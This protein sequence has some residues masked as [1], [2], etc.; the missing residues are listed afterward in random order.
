MMFISTEA[1]QRVLT[2]TIFLAQFAVK[3]LTPTL[4]QNNI[5]IILS[6]ALRYFAA[7]EFGIAAI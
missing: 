7:N 1:L 3:P 4:Q 6:E 2:L 5:A